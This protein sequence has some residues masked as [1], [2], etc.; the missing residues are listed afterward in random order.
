MSSIKLDYGVNCHYKYRC[1]AQ[2]KTGTGSEFATNCIASCFSEQAKK[3]KNRVGM[4]GSR[5]QNV[6][7]LLLLAAWELHSVCF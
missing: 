5:H 2:E 6:I 1:H 7:S 3:D 4:A